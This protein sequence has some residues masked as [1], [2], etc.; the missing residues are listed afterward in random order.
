MRTSILTFIAATLLFQIGLAQEKPTQTVRGKI[1]DNTTEQPLIGASVVLVN[2]NPI[3]GA[4]TDIDGNF[5]MNV[6]VGRQSFAVQYIGYKPTVVPE[7]L[8]TSG[9]QVIFEVKLE[10]SF[11]EKQEVVVSA[12]T[13]KDRP[14]NQ[15]S[16]VSART[17]SMEEVNRFSGGRSDVGR[18]VTNFAGVATSN[19]SRN[20]IVVRG[21][22]PTGVLWRLEGVPIPNPNH[23]A[24]LGT[25]GGP[26]SALNTNLLKTSDFMTGA[27]AAE[28]GNANASVFDLGFRNGNS[29]DHE[30]M[31][32]LGMFSGIEFMG[33][34]PLSKEKGGNYI[35]SARYSFAGIGSSLGIPIGT[36][37]APHYVD[38]NFKVNLPKTKSGDNISIFGIGAYSFINFIGSELSEEDL[39]ADPFSD[40]YP[41]SAFGILGMKHT[42]YLSERGYVRTTVSGTFENSRFDQYNYP[43]SV[44]EFHNTK[45]RDYTAAIRVNSFYNEKVNARLNYRAGITAEIFYLNNLAQARTTETPWT[46]TREFDG[47]L[48][49]IQPFGQVQYKAGKR[50][51]LNGGLHGSYLTLNNSW[52]LEPRTSVVYNF[53]PNHKL[54]FAYGWHSQMQPLPIYFYD[55]PNGDGTFDDG[56]RDLDFTRSH[57]LVLAYDVSFAKSW[58]IKFEPYVQFITGAPVEQFPSSFSV[59]NTGADFGFPERGFL[60]NNGVGR[61]MGVELTLEKFFSKGYYGLLTASLFDSKYKGSDGVWR[62]TTFNNQ[63]VVNFLAGKEFKVGR[64]K[65]NAITTDIRFSTSGGR[66]YTPID[67]DASI[68]ADAEVLQDDKAFSEQYDMYLRLDVK[69]GFRLNSKKKNIS[70]SFYVDFQNVTFQDNIFL[71]RYNPRTQG[72]TNVY[73]IGFFPDVMY[74]INF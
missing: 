49:L 71:S 60:T 11:V 69:V 57:H 29:Q 25:T 66:W 7:V 9:K 50:V 55:A 14:N 64:D 8:V 73:Q 56:N 22:S 46:R 45:V 59:L 5:E 41:R 72:I 4:S 31:F 74:R 12:S 10:E 19:D 53:L 61:N 26:V 68:A 32:Q 65:Q 37:A 42:K 3:V 23:F 54:T 24:T 35:A 52:S 20:D 15:Y 6:P 63:Y 21:N 17:F 1:I 44:N 16:T 67:L 58:R 30:F 70:H 28:Y 40:S 34:G 13:K 33:E 38:L 2:S 36:N 43:D 62:N 39:F 51:T 18:L 27:F 48:G 47:A